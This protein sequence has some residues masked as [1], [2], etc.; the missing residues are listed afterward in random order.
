[1]HVCRQY[2]S[3]PILFTIVDLYTLKILCCFLQ[4]LFESEWSREEPKRSV[5]GEKEQAENQVKDRGWYSLLLS[6]L[7]LVKES[8]SNFNLFV[9]KI[10]T[11]L[12][13]TS[14]SA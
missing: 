7:L 5:K 14:S 6:Y 3:G 10:A 13:G 2:I 1:M 4:V 8:E 11:R 12:S 9:S